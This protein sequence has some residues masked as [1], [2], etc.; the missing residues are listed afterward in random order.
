M[1]DA[2]IAN[3]N[4]PPYKDLH[5]DRQHPEAAKKTEGNNDKGKL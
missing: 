5:Q 2:A 1:R 4:P 3:E